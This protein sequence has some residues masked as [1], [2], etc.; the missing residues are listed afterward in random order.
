[1]VRLV[2]QIGVG[3]AAVVAA[4]GAAPIVVSGQVE[5]TFTAQPERIHRVERSADLSLSSWSV[6]QM[7]EPEPAARQILFNESPG[8]GPQ[9]YRVV[10]AAPAP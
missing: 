7:Y 8:A 4:H 6:R 1:M 9:F 3:V 2:L 10:A 5:L